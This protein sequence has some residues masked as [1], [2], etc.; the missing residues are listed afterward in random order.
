MAA[1]QP[2]DPLPPDENV[3]P[4]LVGVSTVLVFAAVV[5]GGLRLW[6]RYAHRI[7]GWDDYLMMIVLPIVVGRLAI[8][9]VQLQYGNG[10]HRWYIDEQDYQINNMLGWYTQHTLFAGMCI[11]K[12]SIMFLL[13][14][15]KSTPTLRWILGIVMAGLVI[16][17]GGCMIILLA[18]CRPISAYWTGKGEC[19]NNSIRI[20]SIYVTICKYYLRGFSCIVRPTANTKCSGSIF[21]RNRPVVLLASPCRCLAGSHSFENQDSGLWFDELRL[22]VSYHRPHCNGTWGLTTVIKCDRI[23]R[24]PSDGAGYLYSRPEL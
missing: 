22:G 2:P 20:N 1:V 23:R 15:I 14:R 10:R 7:L 11:L 13:L 19:W 24:S 8:Q 21:T 4:V 12:C 6:V 18:E 9:G 5:T 17:N 3:G 16:T